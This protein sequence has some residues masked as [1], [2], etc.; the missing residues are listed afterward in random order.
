MRCNA[1]TVDEYI[2]WLPAE[3]AEQLEPLIQ[4]IRLN[5]PKGYEESMNWGMPCWEIPLSTF[6]NT[7]NKK[8]L[9]YLAVASQ[10]NHFALYMSV[11]YGSQDVRKKVEK[12]FT[13]E[14]KK[15]NMGGSC[16]RFKKLS[17]LPLEGLMEIIKRVKP[18]D[19]IA[20]YE[21]ARPTKN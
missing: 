16:I 18:E 11:A 9:M 20:Y 1:T 17:D 6:P 7:Y 19:Y 21:A 4:A 14:G 2:K 13:N 12:L 5:I 8:P 15:L 10:K 3:R